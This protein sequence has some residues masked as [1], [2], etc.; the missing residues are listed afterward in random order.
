MLDLGG[1]PNKRN[2]RGETIVHCICAVVNEV[3]SLKQLQEQKRTDCLV[4][5]LQWSS[6]TLL[7]GKV[8]KADLAAKDEVKHISFIEFDNFNN[9]F[10][11]QKWF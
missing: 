6:D 5:I 4:F 10:I 1:N 7:D 8:E 9:L 2:S 11:K 3:P